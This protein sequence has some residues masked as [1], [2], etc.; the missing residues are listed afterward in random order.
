MSRKIFFISWA[1]VALGFFPFSVLHNTNV[2]ITF[3]A[4]W[5]IA[6]I[7][8]IKKFQVSPMLRFGA[9]VTSSALIWNEYSG[10]RSVEAA[11]GLFSLLAILKLWEFYSRRDGFL[12]YLIFQLMMTAQYLLLESLWLLV[13]MI[14]STLGMCA[15]FMQL[16]GAKGEKFV[17]MH[18]GKRLVLFRVMLTS[19]GTA[20]IL[21]FVFPRS[22]FTL[23]INP[24]KDQIHP[25]TGFSAKLQPGSITSLMQDDATMFRAT[26]DATTPTMPEM[27]W[28]GNTLI[29]TDGF[30]WR[31]DTRA[32]FANNK[33]Q[34]AKGRHPYEAFMVDSGEGVAFVLSPVSDFD[35][36]TRGLVRW[37]GL[38]DALVKPLST[39]KL[40]WRGSVAL[41]NSKEIESPEDLE[42]SLYLDLDVKDWIRRTYPQW[43]GLTSQQLI[44]EINKLF[45]NDFTYSLSPGRYNGS[46]LEQLQEFLLKRKV[47]VC[48]H[49]A[50]AA[51]VILRAF[52]HPAVVVVG[53]QGGEYN[54]VGDYWIIRGRD[55]HAWT[56]VYNEGQGWSR[57]D[58]TN[59][60]VPTRIQNGATV[61]GQE[62]SEQLGLAQDWYRLARWPLLNQ[63]S[64]FIDSTYYNLNLAFI[65][66]DAQSQRNL[67]DQLG[68]GDWRRSTLKWATFLLGLVAFFIFWW[69]QRG[70]SSN[71]WSKVNEMYQSFG[72][73]LRVLDVNVPSSM[74]PLQLRQTLE[75]KFAL[76]SCYKFIDLYVATKY[77][78]S[79]VAPSSQAVKH[80][81]AVYKEAMRELRNLK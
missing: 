46:P 37:R 65:N 48:E 19:L 27:Y 50:S 45:V 69:W 63:V 2:V 24:P 62:L 30:N 78:A 20:I 57:Y 71:P 1:F 52:N 51:A 36:H 60:V 23:Y 67:L 79:E 13:F 3:A 10:F 41:T 38:G 28:H 33:P 8:R 77:A 32:Y 73:K 61:F 47:G 4:L 39:Q 43:E 44:T 6:F 25:W 76:K 81:R 5:A 49:F 80:L 64:K 17:F 21:F 68:I 26:F 54:E 66:Y 18:K 7:A 15:I 11:A 40:H 35:L 58:P 29:E 12:F 16:Q 22:N 74:P 75:T 42:K 53:F 14:I 55:A 59:Y 56:M 9:L 31:R 34:E 72:K 70:V